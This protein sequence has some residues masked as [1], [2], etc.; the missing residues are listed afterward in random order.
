MNSQV[1]KQSLFYLLLLQS[2]SLWS[3]NGDKQHKYSVISPDGYLS[4]SQLTYADSQ[5]TISRTLPHTSEG[6]FYPE[7]TEIE[8]L[9]TGQLD[10]LGIQPS[11]NNI[12][13]ELRKGNDAIA[14][15]ELGPVARASNQSHPSQETDDACDNPHME[16][17]FYFISPV[18]LNQIKTVL[19]HHF[20]GGQGGNDETARSE[21]MT[22]PKPIIAST[23]ETVSYLLH[24]RNRHLVLAFQKKNGYCH[25]TLKESKDSHEPGE[26][27]RDA[28][29]PEVSMHPAGFRAGEIGIPVVIPPSDNDQGGGGVL[30]LP[31]SQQVGL[32]GLV[33]EPQTKVIF[34]ADLPG[35][36]MAATKGDG[37][38]KKVF[39]YGIQKLHANLS[40]CKNKAI[41]LLEK[42]SGKRNKKKGDED[43]DPDNPDDKK[44]PNSTELTDED[45]KE[46]EKQFLENLDQISSG[47]FIAVN[48]LR[49]RVG[50]KSVD[51]TL[52]G[53]A[54][55]SS[56]TMQSRASD[57]QKTITTEQPV[58]GEGDVELLSELEQE[59][60]ESATL[61]ENLKQVAYDLMAGRK[62]LQDIVSPVIESNRKDFYRWTKKSAW[63]QMSHSELKRYLQG[64]TLSELTQYLEEVK[65]FMDEHGEKLGEALG[66]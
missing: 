3:G 35:V 62:K 10:Q 57:E 28:E 38:G 26:A 7:L 47:T 65:R 54:R 59:H 40:D 63:Q 18:V 5:L 41:S 15:I 21:D 44:K 33:A 58:A 32:P 52:S 31:N 56:I 25:I 12:L 14:S 48:E 16:Q 50:I 19:A 51:S 45:K 2:A 53:Q 6:S 9:M 4:G 8:Q 46:A 60:L 13:L 1:I 66:D 43:D 27:S 29:L 39:E 49:G 64:K 23:D 11:G 17:L 24:S 61:P 36:L 37:G 42:W 30:A 34:V 22:Q 55:R 20:L